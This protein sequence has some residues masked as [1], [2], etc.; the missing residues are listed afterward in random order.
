MCSSW[1][2]WHQKSSLPVPQGNSR[3]S[4]W[5]SRRA[6]LNKNY[7]AD[8]LLLSTSEET[9]QSPA[10]NPVWLQVAITL[11]CNPSFIL[12]IFSFAVLFPEGALVCIHELCYWGKNRI[13]I[14]FI[15][16]NSFHR[17]HES[18]G[19]ARGDEMPVHPQPLTPLIREGA[20]S[21]AGP[22]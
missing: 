2:G 21:G 9:Y 15:A 19:A 8:S 1:R 5:T 20:S 17:H 16:V 14:K 18:E 13:W 11:S 10:V 22:W 4:G 6:W 7:G 3:W 12:F